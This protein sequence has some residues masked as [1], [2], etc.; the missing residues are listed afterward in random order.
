MNHSVLISDI[1]DEIILV[2]DIMN[3]EGFETSIKR[4]IIKVN[5]EEVIL[6]KARV[7]FVR[8][9]IAKNTSSEVILEASVDGTKYNDVRASTK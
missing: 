4:C 8:L 5:G 7:D 9:I 3:A 6:Q 1:E 2:M